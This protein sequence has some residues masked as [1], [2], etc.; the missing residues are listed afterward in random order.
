[1]SHVTPPK[2]LTSAKVPDA[3]KAELDDYLA[4]L[5]RRYGI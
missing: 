1:M 2:W 5:K 3:A 4:Y